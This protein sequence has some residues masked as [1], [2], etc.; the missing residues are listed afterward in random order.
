MAHQRL[1]FLLY[2]VKH[3]QQEALEHSRTAVRLE[4][5]NPFAR[6][7]LGA[8]LFEQG[9]FTNAVI[10]LAEA[11]RLLPNGYDRQ[12]NAIEMNS[13]LAMTQSRLAHYDQCIGPL[14]T[15]LRLAP[16]HPRANYLMAL[17]RARLGQTE[18]AL[19]FFDHASR[20]DPSL[21]QL[22]DFL[23]LLSRNYVSQGLYRRRLESGRKGQPPGRRDRPQPAGR[24]A[25]PARPGVPPPPGSQV[26]AA[27]R[28]DTRGQRQSSPQT[29]VGDDVR[30][31]WVAPFHHYRLVRG[32]AI[33]ISQ[34]A[35]RPRIRA[36]LWISVI[37][38]AALVS[39][40]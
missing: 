31:L 40:F 7:D 18:A 5:H 2:Q 22:P 15:V 35:Q 16:E 32:A 36:A 21:A 23:D 34:I 12:Y 11:V 26:R 6:F 28:G 37:A 1:G 14:E 29:I 8:A 20:A 9:D 19:P 4:P 30:S 38:C 3:Q 13:L 25:R 17:V 10:H 24:Q 39:P 33:W 27:F